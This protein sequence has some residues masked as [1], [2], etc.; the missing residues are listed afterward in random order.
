TPYLPFV[1]ALRHWVDREDIETL[2]MRLGASASVLARLAPR[3]EARLGSLPASAALAPHEERLRLFDSVARLLQSLASERGLLLFLDDLHWAD[4]GTIALLHYLLR[5]LRSERLLVLGAYREVE[6]DRSHPLGAALVEWNRERL[7]TRIPLGRL[8]RM[9]TRRMLGSL[10]GQEDV[11]PDF[12]EA[13]FRETEGN[14]FFTEEVVKSLIEQG[15]IYHEAGEWHRGEAELAIPQS[16]KAAIGRRLERLSAPCVDVLHTAAALG[17]VFEFGELVAVTAAGEDRLL[18][19][20]DEASAAQLVRPERGDSFAFTH[21]KIREVLHEELNPI[22]QRRLHQRIAES[23]ETLYARTLDDHVEDLAYHFAESSDLEKGM[24]YSLAAAEAAEKVYAHEE[25]L[26]FLDRAR[27]CAEGLERRPALADVHERI[28]QVHS[29]RGQF[30]AGAEHFQRALA[31]TSEPRKRAAIKGAIGE[32]LARVGDQRGLPYLE[33][34]LAELDPEAQVYDV[35]LTLANIGRYHHYL[36]QH[37][38]AEEHLERARAMAESI[39]DLRLLALIYGYLSGVFQHLGLFAESNA[40]ARRNIELGER[41][42]EP[43]AEAQGYEFLAENANNLGRWREAVE[44]ARR[45]QEIGRRVGSQDRVAWGGFALAWAHHTGGELDAAVAVAQESLAL[46]ERIGEG[47]LAIWLLVVLSMAETD[48]GRHAEGREH[49]EQA[50]SRGEAIGQMVMRSAATGALA[51]ARLAAG[52]PN[53]AATI[54]RD[55]LPLGEG[56]DN[57][58]YLFLLLPPYAQALVTAG[59]LDEAA[60]ITR[61]GL[62]IAGENAWLY[63]RGDLLWSEGR[64]LAAAGDAVGAERTLSEAITALESIEL[65]LLLA[66][67]L[68]DRGLVGRAQGKQEAARQDLERARDLFE[69][70][71]AAPEHARVVETLA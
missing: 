50:V 31:L 19:A 5:N 3:I 28:G 44:H 4:H 64:R 43:Q 68:H 14:P 49:A 22:R 15:Q 70:C 7:A 25:A 51:Y 33:E 17:K 10:F 61:R 46:A 1:E 12:A 27:E 69:T 38:R 8:D 42:G 54:C 65:R 6:L 40:W 26:S 58:V 29:H 71:G 60:E 30:N 67:A 39:G 32:L 37:R 47:R 9:E 35:A 59:R 62:E 18:D 66:R 57:R 48:L 34:A 20:L 52:E 36:A 11:S 55:C 13:M 63:L 23:L 56:T 45:D 2:R 41:T 24:T 21:D 53:G 16:V